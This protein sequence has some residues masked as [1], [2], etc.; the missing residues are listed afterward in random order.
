MSQAQ[1]FRPQSLTRSALLVAG[2]TLTLPA[3]G[4]AQ[5]APPVFPPKQL[6]T[7]WDF[8]SGKPVRDAVKFRKTDKLLRP[9]FSGAPED[10][11]KGLAAKIRAEELD[12]PK[13]I[14]A[15][16]YL[17]TLDCVAYPEAQ[18]MLIEVLHNDKW[19]PVRLAAAK[20]LGV[21]LTGRCASEEQ[22][23][24]AEEARKKFKPRIKQRERYDTCPGCCNKDV[25]NALAKTAY[26]KLENGCCFEPSLRVRQA[27]VDAINVCGICC[28]NW[29]YPMT[30][31]EAVEP[32]P[33]GEEKPP[34][35]GEE[36]P[37]ME[38]E[39]PSDT[40]AS[41]PGLYP[42]VGSPARLSPDVTQTPGQPSEITA[43][44]GYCIVSLKAKQFYKAEPH[45]TSVYENRTYR[46]WNEAAKREFDR[47]PEAYAV[48]YSGVDPVLLVESDQE[49]EGRFLREYDDRF[50]LFA[51]KENW[52]LFKQNPD[53]YLPA[54]P[55]EGETIQAAHA[56][57]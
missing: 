12:V 20:A 29:Q 4:R 7:V 3:I 36:K 48:L 39:T 42:P 2:L 41:A 22:Q 19:E 34:T 25:L 54:D 10:S 47:V 49:V 6:E 15:V 46:F 51:S 52:E 26:E 37:P 31:P 44:G 11:P 5:D 21:M 8:L 24:K 40:E 56:S 50:L 57:E 27:A 1:L 17:G 23:E 53:L 45:L 32:E 55:E 33:M 9:P 38:G 13:R 18:E 14:Q 30:E 35:P 43:L 16:G 28:R